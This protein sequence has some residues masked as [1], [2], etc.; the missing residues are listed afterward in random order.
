MPDG[1]SIIPFAGFQSF[2]VVTLGA[3]ANDPNR[4]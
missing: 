3:K 2:A 1:S 4:R